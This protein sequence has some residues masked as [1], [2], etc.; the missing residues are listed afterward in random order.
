VA[1][2]RP[3][4]SSRHVRAI[5]VKRVYRPHSRH[6]ALNRLWEM[7]STRT[8]SCQDGRFEEASTR[9]RHQG[10]LASAETTCSVPETPSSRVCDSDRNR[11][12]RWFCTTFDTRGPKRVSREAWLCG[13]SVHRSSKAHTPRKLREISQRNVRTSFTGLARADKQRTG[14]RRLGSKSMGVILTQHPRRTHT[15]LNTLFKH[16][17]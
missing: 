14:N 6:Y 15:S 9:C 11:A 5:G 13:L 16:R 8:R 1:D 12:E 2:G 3:Y 17:F 7:R 10:A 4:E